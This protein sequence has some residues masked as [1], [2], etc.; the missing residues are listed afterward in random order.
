[1]LEEGDVSSE[2]LRQPERGVNSIRSVIIATG[3]FILDAFE[4]VSKSPRKFIFYY[5]LSPFSI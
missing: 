4:P 5:P 1:L 3:E 2:L